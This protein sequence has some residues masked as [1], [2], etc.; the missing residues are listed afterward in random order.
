[1]TGRLRDVAT[2]AG[3]AL[4]TASL[5]LKGGPHVS[6]QVRGRVLEAA[7]AVRYDVGRLSG[8]AVDQAAWRDGRRSAGHAPTALL[9]IP[10]HSHAVYNSY[11]APLVAT[12]RAAARARG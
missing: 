8:D 12:V 11:F 9:L 4:S 5:A 1:M 10:A 3:V 2:R 7:R 6:E